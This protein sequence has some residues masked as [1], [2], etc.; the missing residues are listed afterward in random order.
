MVET[1]KLLKMMMMM[2]VVVPVTQRIDDVVIGSREGGWLQ[3]PS[4]VVAVF[5]G[6]RTR[7]SPVTGDSEVEM[8]FYGTETKTQRVKLDIGQGCKDQTTRFKDDQRV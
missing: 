7:R 2:G 5:I 4:Q 3:H 6:T 1:P 8:V